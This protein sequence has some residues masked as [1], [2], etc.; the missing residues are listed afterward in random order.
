MTV[1]AR[2]SAAIERAAPAKPVS[3]C[4]SWPSCAAPATQYHGAGACVSLPSDYGPSCLCCTE[5]CSFGH[6][7]VGLLA[8]VRA[9]L[10]K[11]GLLS[12]WLALQSSCPDRLRV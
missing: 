5:M 9:R 12:P 1:L 10:M 4:V 6:V 8:V 7:V 11:G 3:L 2:S